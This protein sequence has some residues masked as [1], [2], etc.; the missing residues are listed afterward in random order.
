MYKL[1]Q[2]EVFYDW[3]G[4]HVI[5]FLCYFQPTNFLVAMKARPHTDLPICYIYVTVDIF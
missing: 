3:L 4:L 2:V 1:R 5:S